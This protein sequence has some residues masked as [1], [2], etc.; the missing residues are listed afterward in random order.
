[1]HQCMAQGI[2]R[3][4]GNTLNQQWGSRGWV[5]PAGLCSSEMSQRKSNTPLWATNKTIHSSCFAYAQKENLHWFEWLTV[6]GGQDEIGSK[7]MTHLVS[8][9]HSKSSFVGGP[10]GIQWRVKSRSRGLSSFYELWLHNGAFL[11]S[12][13]SFNKQSKLTLKTHS[14]T[15]TFNKF[16]EG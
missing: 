12:L 2:R 4:L 9:T 10:S 16:S 3:R 6:G 1:M 8:I 7:V 11:L 5:Q 14:H 13:Y 15:H